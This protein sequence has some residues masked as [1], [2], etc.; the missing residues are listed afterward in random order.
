MRSAVST[1]ENTFHITVVIP[2]YNAASHIERAIRSVLA[3]TYP[4]DEVIVVNDGSA[5]QTSEIVRQFGSRVR[6][7]EQ[8]NAGV[9]A[10]RNAGIQAAAGQWIAFLDADDEWLPNHLEKHRT[11][12]SQN[13]FLVWSTGNFLTCSCLE[14]R[15]AA[16]I[17]P[18]YAKQVL[19]AKQY[20]EDYLVGCQK[21]MGGCSDTMI[22]Q[23]RI[24]MEAGL[25]AVG[26]ARGEDLDLWWRIAYRHP[27]VGYVDEP[28]AIYHVGVAGSCTKKMG[29]V[30]DYINPIRR[31]LEL[32]GQ[33]G[34]QQAFVPVAQ[35]YTRLWIRSMLFD[36]RSGDIRRL[37]SEFPTFYSFGYKV[38]IHLLTLFPS[39]TAAGC[40]IISK[41]VRT[42]HL[43]RRLVAPPRKIKS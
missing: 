22:I 33:A 29:E 26:V 37:I 31:H 28:T 20:L 13:P 2:A 3:Q 1:M 27:Q 10:A 43:R 4:A 16:F 39:L 7:I 17:T 19:G 18:Q 21:E 8:A 15:Q 42:L 5:D 40:R 41:V 14:K 11:L 24:L 9:S 12:L 36:A 25:F 32:S 30:A 38:C 23:R 34:R 35:Q 6:L